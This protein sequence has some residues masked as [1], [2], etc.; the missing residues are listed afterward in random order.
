MDMRYLERLAREGSVK[1]VENLLKEFGS[2]KWTVSSGIGENEND[3]EVRCIDFIISGI[4]HDI[5]G[6]F[7]NG[8]SRSEKETLLAQ[9]ETGTGPFKTEQDVPPDIVKEL[10]DT[11]AELMARLEKLEKA[12]PKQTSSAPKP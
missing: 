5:G 11:I 12:T 3:K 2:K 6:A 4:H 10:R 8:D 9:Y 7:D 1:D